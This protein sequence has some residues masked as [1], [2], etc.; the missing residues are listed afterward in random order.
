MAFPLSRDFVRLISEDFKDCRS[1]VKQ[2]DILPG[3]A[4]SET[5]RQW[6]CCRHMCDNEWDPI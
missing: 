3:P 5:L 6:T 2:R 4:K 1:D